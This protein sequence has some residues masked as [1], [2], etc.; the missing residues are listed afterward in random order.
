MKKILTIV[1]VG[2]MGLY[3]VSCNEKAGSGTSPLADTVSMNMGTLMGSYGEQLK[4]DSTIDLQQVIKGL[5]A[6]LNTD[7]ANHGYMMGM[8][9]GMQ[10]LS[11]FMQIKD[12][13]GIDI[14]KRKFVEAFKKS[15]LADSVNREEMM[16]MNMNM[17]SLLMRARNEARA[18]EAKKNKADGEAFLAKKAKEAGYQKTES[19]LLYKVI[20]EG[21]G[22]NFT[23]KDVVLVNY[24]GKHI[25]GKVFDQSKDKP[26]S[27]PLN[28]VIPGFAEMI[29]LMKPG[30]KVEVIIPS[31]LAYG[32]EGTEGEIGPNET[33][34]FEM[35][36]VGVDTSV[37]AAPVS[38]NPVRK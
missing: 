30:Q 7:T 23:D 31:N 16:A 6:A 20:T 9:M 22:E 32:E 2:L 18:P 24:V 21:K 10:V 34:I 5:E 26:A 12:Q 35:E 11:N 15:L 4:N 19:G 17:Q 36:T 14:N 25:D 29:K 33:L 8:Q 37:P 13:Y 28:G 27:F 38:A 1:L 3:F